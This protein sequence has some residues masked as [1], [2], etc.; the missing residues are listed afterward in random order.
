M[1]MWDTLREP[2]STRAHTGTF[3]AAVARVWIVVGSR[4]QRVERSGGRGMHR[5]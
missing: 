2:E 3:G 4:D 5:G 1:R